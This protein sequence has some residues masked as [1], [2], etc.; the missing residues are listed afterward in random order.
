MAALR[1]ASAVTLCATAVSIDKNSTPK[2][3]ALLAL[4][5]EI[6]G[7]LSATIVWVRP[8]RQL[9]PPSSEFGPHSEEVRPVPGL[10]AVEVAEV[11]RVVKRVAVRVVG[12]L[13]GLPRP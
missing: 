2:M 9:R 10:A 5:A 4:C 8:E 3:A 1:Y 6:N 12:D 11:E 13:L 7:W